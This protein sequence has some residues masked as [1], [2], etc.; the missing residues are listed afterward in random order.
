M[1]LQVQNR[2][3]GRGPSGRTRHV[4]LRRAACVPGLS[5]T[6]NANGLVVFDGAMRDVT[7]VGS[8]YIEVSSELPE[9]P[10]KAVL[11]LYWGDGS[12]PA[13]SAGADRSAP[14]PA[15]VSAW[16][17]HPPGRV[18]SEAG[19]RPRCRGAWAGK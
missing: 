15:S 9:L 3:R 6:D 18:C 11:V 5:V 13:R 1:G 4:K 8:R 14:A 2:E 17:W 16:V 7:A 10:E 12:S 19:R